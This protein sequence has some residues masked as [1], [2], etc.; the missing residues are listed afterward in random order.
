M[1]QREVSEL[2]DLHGGV[3]VFICLGWWCVFRLGSARVL[4]AHGL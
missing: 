4:L 2:Q 1:V 3:C